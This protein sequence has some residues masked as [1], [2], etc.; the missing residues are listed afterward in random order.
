MSGSRSREKGKRGEREVA[1][2]ARAAGFED[3]RRTQDGNVQIGR[4]DVTGVP[5]L[6]L[7]VKRQETLKVGEWLAQAYADADAHDVPVVAFRRN[8]DKAWHATVPLAWL[9]ALVAEKDG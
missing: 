9:L 3:V 1:A 7:E 5:G 8:G 2:L 6:H 4:G